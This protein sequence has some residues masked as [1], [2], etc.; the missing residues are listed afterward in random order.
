MRDEEGTREEELNLT[1]EQQ[2]LNIR[3]ESFTYNHIN[4]ITSCSRSTTHITQSGAIHPAVARYN[5]F[6]LKHDYTPL[7]KYTTGLN[8]AEQRMQP[9]KDENDQEEMIRAEQHPGQ[10]EMIQAEQNTGQPGQM[11]PTGQAEPMLPIDASG[12]AE[13]SRAEHQQKCQAE[14]TRTEHHSCLTG[15]MM[16]S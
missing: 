2:E 14:G 4:N 8:Q 12:Q 9:R 1:A 6:Q 13:M 7:T 10:A 16:P 15:Q 5:K 11:Q 3:D